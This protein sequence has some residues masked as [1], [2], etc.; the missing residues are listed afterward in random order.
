MF[1]YVVTI[2]DTDH[3]GVISKTEQRTY[4]ELVLGDLSLSVDGD[5]LRVQLVSTAFPRVE[6]MMEGLGDILVDFAADI[7]GDR[8][9]RKLVFENH[10]QSPIA[11]YLVNCLVPRDPDIRIA[12]QNRNYEQA[13]YQLEYTQNG[14]RAEPLSLTWWS[15]GRGWLSLVGLVLLVRLAV[16]LRRS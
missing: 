16:V 12:A 6:Q 14:G 2:I 9:T 11:T 1:R 7:P 4:A 13:L 8:K 3:D 5:R 10:H 15:D